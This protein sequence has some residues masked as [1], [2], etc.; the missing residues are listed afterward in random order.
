MMALVL[1]ESEEKMQQAYEAL[2]REFTRVR[3]GKAS[4]ALLDGIR[5]EYYGSQIPLRQ[6]ANISAPE[7]RLLVVQPW[8]R[9]ALSA[10]EK[11]IS[12]SEIGLHPL[13]DGAVIRL[14]IPKL[15]EER[16]KELVRHVRKLSEDVRVSVRNIRRGQIEELRK[17]EKSGDIT[18]DDLHK[19]SDR[20]QEITDR[21]V[22]MIDDLMKAKEREVMEV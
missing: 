20:I 21:H 6:V 9:T 17:F 12:K 10:I 4:P 8:D 5:V 2:K 14:P 19:G 22:A 15:T 13:N 11:A 3:T 1:E 7:P 16:R 18:E